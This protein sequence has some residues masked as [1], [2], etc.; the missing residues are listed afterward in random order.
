MLKQCQALAPHMT[1]TI[2]QCLFRFWPRNDVYLKKHACSKI[3]Y[4]MVQNNMM[5]IWKLWKAQLYVETRPPV[6]WTGKNEYGWV[7]VW[8]DGQWTDKK[9]EGAKKASKTIDIVSYALKVSVKWCH[10]CLQL[11]SGHQAHLKVCKLA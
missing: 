5:Y 7:E 9:N 11:I 2:L 1:A 3:T 10:V 4:F 6:I 8:V